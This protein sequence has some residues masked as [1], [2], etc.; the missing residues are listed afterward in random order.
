MVNCITVDAQLWG[1]QVR[2][3]PKS[4]VDRKGRMLTQREIT[5]A[6]WRWRLFSAES[7][8]QH[9]ILALQNSAEEV[10][11]IVKEVEFLACPKS[12]VADA[13]GAALLEKWRAALGLP[14]FYGGG[15]PSL[16]YLKKH[17]SEFLAR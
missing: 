7:M 3:I 16:H 15:L 11:E 13:K 4:V 6:P 8:M 9:G 1:K 17:E 2:F 14:H 5:S 12:P 10:L